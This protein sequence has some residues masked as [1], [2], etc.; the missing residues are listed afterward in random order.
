MAT[1]E[2]ITPNA[3]PLEYAQFD[4]GDHICGTKEQLQSIGIGVGIPFPGEPGAPRRQLC[5]RDPR[6]LAAKIRRETYRRDDCFS[7]S[8]SFPGWS[9]P[10]RP[11]R[12]FAA[13]VTVLESSWGD[14][15]IGTADAL[16]AAGLIRLE[17]LPGQL[18]MRKIRVTVYA[19]GEVAGGVATKNDAKAK[20]P[21]SK[22][23]ERAR[24]SSYKVTVR[25]SDEES[26]ARRQAH[27]LAQAHWKRKLSTMQR[28]APLCPVPEPIESQER[29]RLTAQTAIQ[30]QERCNTGSRTARAAFL[31]YYSRLQVGDVCANEN[32]ELLEIVEGYDFYRVTSDDG[33]YVDETGRF[34]W[35]DGY[36]ARR[37]GGKPFFFAAGYL[38]APDGKPMH[39]RAAPHRDASQARSG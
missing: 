32:G 39:L 27:D 5:V 10:E 13:G 14:E 8:I 19:N 2:T 20:A 12:E 11:P 38:A 26:Q 1:Q 9:M 17:H 24:R 6:G 22:V 31:P 7:A 28:P 36:V 30:G 37:L 3:P 16:S 21:G 34:D 23:I 4:W 35:R 18:G 15:Y 33:E 25:I 29:R